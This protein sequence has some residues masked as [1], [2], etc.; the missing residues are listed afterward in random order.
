[1]RAI[2]AL[3]YGIQPADPVTIVALPLALAAVALAPC[4]WPARRAA[5]LNPIAALRHE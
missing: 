3:L 2:A 5:R 4:Y 1:M